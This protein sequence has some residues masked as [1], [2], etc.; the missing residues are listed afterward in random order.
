MY[1]V[2]PVS[3]FKHPFLQ[4]QFVITSPDQIDKMVAYGLKTVTIDTE[5]G[6]GRSGPARKPEN[7]AENE[8]KNRPTPVPSAS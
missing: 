8:V 3:W 7:P 6:A 1:V 4:N 5:R 2:L